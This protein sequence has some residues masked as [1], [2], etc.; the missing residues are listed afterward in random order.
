MGCKQ[1]KLI[2]MKEILER[3]RLVRFTTIFP[4]VDRYYLVKDRNGDPWV[5]REYLHNGTYPRYTLRGKYRRGQGYVAANLYARFICCCDAESKLGVFIEDIVTAKMGA[6]IGSWMM[7]SL[8][9]F[10]RIS[11]NLANIGRIYGD[12]IRD[13]VETHVRRVNF[14]KRF[15]F[16]VEQIRTGR[17][18]ITA[19]L[20]ELHEVALPHLQEI[21]L[22]Y[23]LTQWSE[24]ASSNKWIC[25]RERRL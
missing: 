1:R 11:D 9:S 12:I 18:N 20:S 25:C 24:K 15:G 6:G 5:F 17:V 23:A 14:F 8:I 2:M 19:Y 10:L 22:E 4:L 13:S 7:N 3:L 16:S 21:D